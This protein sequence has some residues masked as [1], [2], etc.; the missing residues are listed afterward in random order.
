M[1]KYIVSTSINPPTDAIKQF[2]SMDDWN[3][4]VIGDRKTP[5]FKLENGRYVSPEEQEVLEFESVKHIPWNCIQRRSIG[6]LLAIKEGADIIALVDDDNLPLL[7]PLWQ[8]SALA[9]TTDYMCT[10][11]MI[12]S[13]LPVCDILYMHEDYLNC[14]KIWH[15]GFP[16]QLLDQRHKQTVISA[17]TDEN[18][19]MSGPTKNVAVVASLWEMEP[20]IDAICRIANGPH[21]VSFKSDREY[22]V[23]P[24]IFSPFNSQNTMFSNNINIC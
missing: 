6:I 24:K 18:G 17:T 4:I 8:D 2:D 13:D 16:I 22:L 21:D 15:R 9:L 7:S 23:D 14:G 19:K 10:G 5:E 12:T 11:D 1:K 3:L 20:D